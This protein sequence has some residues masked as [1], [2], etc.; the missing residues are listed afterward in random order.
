MVKKENSSAKKVKP[1]KKGK[2]AIKAPSAKKVSAKKEQKHIKPE[3][4]FILCTGGIIKNV[5][6]LALTIDYLSDE[7]F[8]HHVNDERNDFSNWLRDVF[9]EEIL[10]DALAS[11]C[12]RKDCQIMLLKHLLA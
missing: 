1:Q 10:A 5:K 3:N 6:E 7:E 11:S 4:Y 12:D 2:K 9:K 8:R